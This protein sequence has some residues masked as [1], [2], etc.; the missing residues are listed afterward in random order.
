MEIVFPNVLPEGVG[1]AMKRLRKRPRILLTFCILVIIVFTAIVVFQHFQLNNFIDKTFIRISGKQKLIVDIPQD[2]ERNQICIDWYG[3]TDNPLVFTDSTGWGKIPYYEGNS[4]FSVYYKNE[5]IKTTGHFVVSKFGYHNYRFIFYKLEGKVD[6]D[7]KI[8]G[9][10]GSTRKEWDELYYWIKGPSV[11]KQSGQL[12]T[13]KS[14]S[15]AIKNH[16]DFTINQGDL[17]KLLTP[18][19]DT[20]IKKLDCS[21]NDKS[22]HVKT[23]KTR[24]SGSLNYR[25]KCLTVTLKDSAEFNDD[26]G[27][28]RKLKTFSLISLSM[29]NYYFRNRLANLLLRQ[30]KILDIFNT[31][32][33]VKMNSGTQGVYMLIEEPKKHLLDS[34]NASIIIRHRYDNSSFTDQSLIGRTKSMVKRI[35]GYDKLEYNV[36]NDLSSAETE[37]SLN[38]YKKIHKVIHKYKGEELYSE[39]GKIMNIDEYMRIMAFNY[40]ICNQDYTDEQFYYLSGKDKSSVFNIMP[41]DFD[42]ILGNSPHEGWRQRNRYLKGKLI[43][44][45]ENE[46]DRTIGRDLVLYKKYQIQMGKVTG[47]LDPAFV[48]VICENLYIQLYPYYRNEEIMKQ[49]EYDLFHMQYKLHDLKDQLNGTYSF[50]YQRINTIK[51]EL[52]TEGISGNQ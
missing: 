52:A 45:G 26:N 38:Q 11:I 44:S 1:N 29:D 14:D 51:T 35:I 31:Y 25:R 20:S 15:A 49:S 13:L 40:I 33:E 4:C 6:F 19:F 24:G 39:L 9:P 48:K 18:G 22:Y 32:T 46:L 50:L 27:S 36:Y 10:D 7:L 34:M 28:V 23:L 16:I 3:P 5:L 42:D 41:W 30:A 37:K 12:L 8:I 17:N 43:F 47:S 2:I 21:I